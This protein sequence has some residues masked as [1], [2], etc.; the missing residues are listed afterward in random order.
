MHTP[1]HTGDSICLWHAPSRTLLCADT[2]LGWGSTTVADLR[3]YM[4]SL[5]E[6]RALEPHPLALLPGHGPPIVPSRQQGPTAVQLIQHYIDHRNARISQ[7]GSKSLHF[8]V[9]CAQRLLQVMDAVK[10]LSKQDGIPALLTT[11]V[12]AQEVRHA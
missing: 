11:S 7:V 10:S 4:A 12:I 1:G 9:G 6:L 2:L 5:K 3:N 8:G